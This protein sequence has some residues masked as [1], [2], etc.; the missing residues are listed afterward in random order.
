MFTVT[1]LAKQW[2]CCALYPAEFL[3]ECI[4]LERYE[5]KKSSLV[6]LDF[7]SLILCS[8]NRDWEKIFRWIIYLPKYKWKSSELFLNS[9][10]TQKINISANLHISLGSNKTLSGNWK[11]KSFV[12][13]FSSK[14][15]PPN[16]STIHT[17]KIN[18]WLFAIK[19]IYFNLNNRYPKH[20]GVVLTSSW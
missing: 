17:R 2:G 7:R 18:I 3:R 15:Q 20:H 5:L 16:Q 19:H 13:F 14:F 10:L 9:L 12:L 8:V 6:C 4:S 11:K 1:W